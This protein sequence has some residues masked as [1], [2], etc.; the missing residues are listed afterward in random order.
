LVQVDIEQGKT[1]HL[2]LL[3]KGQVNSIGEREIFFEMNGHLRSIF[4][5]D[6]DA[7]KVLRWL[8]VVY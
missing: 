4:V 8:L 7:M 2:K 6:M 1:L 3:A 5:K